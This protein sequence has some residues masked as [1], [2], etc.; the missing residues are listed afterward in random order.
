[1][2]TK[3]KKSP[4][5]R[6]SGTPSALIADAKAEAKLSPFTV[7]SAIHGLV[8]VVFIPRS[9]RQKSGFFV[10]HK[11]GPVYAVHS[12]FSPHVEVMEKTELTQNLREMRQAHKNEQ[13]GK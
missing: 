5:K 7:V 13:K 6:T 10:I 8:S 1:M 2:T 3:V 12:S 4:T 11:V 9:K